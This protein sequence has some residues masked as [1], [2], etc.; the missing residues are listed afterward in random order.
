M[1]H[2]RLVES[3]FP[4]QV[5]E[6]CI[7]Q[8]VKPSTRCPACHKWGKTRSGVGF[9]HEER[10]THGCDLTWDSEQDYLLIVTDRKD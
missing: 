3:K 5:T 1:K 6:P 4:V 9:E 8:Y 10:C 7:V 2:F